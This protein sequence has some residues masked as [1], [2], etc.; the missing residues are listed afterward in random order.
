MTDPS[1]ELS[2]LGDRLVAQ[3][4]PRFRDFRV[5][6]E[7]ISTAAS[8]AVREDEGSLDLARALFLDVD[9]ALRLPLQ[10]R[11]AAEQ[12]WE[13]LLRYHTTRVRRQWSTEPWPDEAASDVLDLFAAGGRADLGL[14]LVRAYV[15]VMLKRLR[16]DLSKRNPRGPGPQYDEGTRRVLSTMDAA[17]A[18]AIPDRKRELLRDLDSVAP[19]VVAHGADEDRE[20]LDSVRR[21][22]G[23]ERRA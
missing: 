16:K 13:P 8:Q 1:T 2:A 14:E 21:E 7:R 12:A 4:Q 5:D 19:W 17:V 18:A 10:R 22:V 11:Y 3:A 6:F 15:D 20:W 23:M 9:W